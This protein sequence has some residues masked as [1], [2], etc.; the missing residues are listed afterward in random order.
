MKAIL[1]RIDFSDVQTLGELV[2]LN[3]TGEAIYE[4]KTLELEQD[5]NAVRDDCI[6]KGTYQVIKRYS[7]KYKN[8]F[9]VLDVPNR[10]YIL[11]HAGNYNRHTLGCIL[12]GNAHIDINND[13]YKDVTSSKV[14]MKEL[15]KILPEKFELTIK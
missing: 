7:P 11:I 6:P 12:V 8:H 1:T 14:T 15:N 4:C 13:G 3:D 10:S 2:I 9:H 5:R